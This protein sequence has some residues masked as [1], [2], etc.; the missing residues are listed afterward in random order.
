MRCADRHVGC[1]P[2]SLVHMWQL[3][4]LHTT[5]A[6]TNALSLHMYCCVMI[7][8]LLSIAKLLHMHNVQAPP[9]AQRQHCRYTHYIFDCP[10]GIAT[11]PANLES[12]S[13]ML[14]YGLDLFFARIQPNKA[15]D[16]LQD[17]FPY[18][19]LVFITVMLTA[20][21]FAFKRIDDKSNIQRRW[22]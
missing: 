4:L 5:D 17:D 1:L 14:A 9:A 19:F 6:V 2:I 3:V 10:A 16:S 22:L 21:V 18:A 12:T 13:L 8:L 11:A 20:A 7:R 15:F